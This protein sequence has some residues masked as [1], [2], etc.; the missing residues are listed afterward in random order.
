LAELLDTPKVLPSA[1]SGSVESEEGED[2]PRANVLREEILNAYN[3]VERE[4][5]KSASS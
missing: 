3:V 2:S 4:D 1:S 5:E